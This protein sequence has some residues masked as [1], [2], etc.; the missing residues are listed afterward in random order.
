MSRNVA[1]DFKETPKESFVLF[2]SERCGECAKFN[3]LLQEYPE[4]NT[5]FKKIPIEKINPNQVPSQ[6]THVPGI[7]TGN[8]LIMGPNA[9]RWL[10]DTVKRYFGSGPTLSA[11][12]GF[13]DNNFSFIGETET[14][15]N[16][17]FAKFGDETQNNGSAIDPSGFDP[18]TGQSIQAE[19]SGQGGQGGA[20]RT[21]PP[22]LQPQQITND[23][24]M[25]EQDYTRIQQARAMQDQQIKIPGQ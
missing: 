18:R 13:D 20:N 22:Q 9:F 21:L 3:K 11:K 10:G 7:I 19:Q 24:K 16:P 14:D 8:Q 6:L 2:Y 23:G 25:N 1:S 4:L 15:Y 12:G 17:G 5:C